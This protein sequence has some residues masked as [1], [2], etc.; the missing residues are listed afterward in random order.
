[1]NSMTKRAW[2]NQMTLVMCGLLLVG[3]APAP[4]TAAPMSQQDVAAAVETWVHAGTAD[5]RP[6]A[7]VVRMEPH[8]VDGVTTAYIAH[9]S[10]GGYCICGADDGLLPVYLYNPRTLYDPANPGC[11]LVL[12]Q[13][14]RRL[15]WLQ[16]ARKTGDPKLAEYEPRLDQRAATWQTLIAGRLPDAGIA[17]GIESEPDMVVLPLTDSWHQGSPYNDQ[18]PN[19]WPGRDERTV[20]GCVA[21]SMTQVMHYWQWPDTGQGTGSWDWHH[22]WRTYPD[23]EP[24]VDDPN[25]SGW[26]L[27]D[28]LFWFA[29]YLYMDGYWDGSIWW[30][31]HTLHPDN[32]S[33]LDALDAL[34]DRANQEDVPNVADFGA[35][36][37][38]WS[39]IKDEHDDD[40]VDAGDM[41]VAKLAYH[42]GISVG[43]RWG[44]LGSASTLSV[45][46]AMENNWRYH[47]DYTY[48]A[49]DFDTIVD[50]IR[51]FRP[52]LMGGGAED[53]GGHQWVA[54][55]YNL[56]AVPEPEILFNMGWGSGSTS[57]AL[58]DY[59]F[60]VDQMIHWQIVPNTGIYFVDNGTSGGSGSPSDPYLGLSEAIASAPDET[61]LIFKAGS[62]HAVSGSPGVISKPL[63]LKGYDVT[64]TSSA[65]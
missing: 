33:F 59:W 54:C 24:L 52:V 15:E 34:W 26:Y 49:S 1:M 8:T 37:Y 48:S 21:T 16:Q 46:D 19:V 36:T 61:T 5:A 20:V 58:L 47:P 53:G 23:T 2:R 9:L 57:W 18:C 63:I 28:R 42:V 25:L 38:D 30:K 17:A 12:Q 11:R 6:D 27:D 41:E 44:L 31:L 56:G 60:P 45:E 14:G 39:I 7:V 40:P 62:T 35:T 43:M 32:Q 4:A 51:W 13:I 64:I 65:P 22:R 3:L 50:E 55:G 10:G 29:G